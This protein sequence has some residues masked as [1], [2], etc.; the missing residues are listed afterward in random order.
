METPPAYP[1]PLNALGQEILAINEAN[2]WNVTTPADWKPA[3]EVEALAFWTFNKPV[4]L[5]QDDCMGRVK[6]WCYWRVNA[7]HVSSRSA[8]GTGNTPEEAMDD[9][10]QKALA[11]PA[12]TYKIPAVLA[13]IGS[14][15][16]EALEG[17]RNRDRA[18]FEEELADV[19]IRVL[20]LAAG[21][22][23]DM[24]EQVKRKL[25]ANRLRGF[26]HGNKVV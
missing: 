8:S 23:V 18:N 26:R 1:A 9:C 7:Q 12:L 11:C 5:E 2:G 10:R 25:A 17:F 14:E 4:W 19:V 15:V 21:L 3:A 6:A 22:G 13:L 24:D 16:S 20:D